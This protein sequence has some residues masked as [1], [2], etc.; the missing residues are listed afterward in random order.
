MRGGGAD[1]LT[2]PQSRNHSPQNVIHLR[3][4]SFNL[5]DPSARFGQNSTTLQ[6]DAGCALCYPSPG[7]DF[8]RGERA[9]W[10]RSAAAAVNYTQVHNLFSQISALQFAKITHKLFRKVGKEIVDEHRLWLH[11]V[12]R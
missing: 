9:T 8:L 5:D 11:H 12:Y 4:E 6:H 2:P 1:H 7:F 10:L 3:I